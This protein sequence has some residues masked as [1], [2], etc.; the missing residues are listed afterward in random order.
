MALSAHMEVTDMGSDSQTL[1]V[2][3]SLAESLAS[4]L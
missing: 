2:L 3:V 4:E 1:Q